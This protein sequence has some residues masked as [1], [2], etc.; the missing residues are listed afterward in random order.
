MYVP[1]ELADGPQAAYI[2]PAAGEDGQ[3]VGVQRQEE[4]LGGELGL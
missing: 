3:V 2:A 4:A 1:V